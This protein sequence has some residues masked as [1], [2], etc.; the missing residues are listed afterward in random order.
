MREAGKSNM[1]RNDG[2]Q[3]LT[4][5]DKPLLHVGKFKPE[6]GHAGGQHEIESRRH[7]RLMTAVNFT[8]ATFCAV[9]MDGIADR[10]PG[11]NYADTRNFA[12]RMSGTNPPSQE[13]G[14][15]INAATLL[16][17]GTEIVVAPQTLP[18]AKV[19]LTRR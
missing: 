12:R 7:E 5:M 1:G 8:E 13:K 2:R 3:L 4:G 18:G 10:S 16:T 15:A 9:A 11:S 19:H 17:D 14:P 6:Q